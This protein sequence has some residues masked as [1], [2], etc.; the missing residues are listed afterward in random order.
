[1]AMPNCMAAIPS[2]FGCPGKIARIAPKFHRMIS[3]Q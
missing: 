3:S 1:M 2:T